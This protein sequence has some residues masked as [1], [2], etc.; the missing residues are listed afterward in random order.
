MSAYF[1]IKELSNRTGYSVNTLY[2]KTKAL[3]LGYKPFNGKLLF[4]D[5]VVDFLVKGGTN[6]NIER[7]DIREKRLSIHLDEIFN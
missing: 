7:N 4:D 6:E 3:K 1:D 2:K 5:S